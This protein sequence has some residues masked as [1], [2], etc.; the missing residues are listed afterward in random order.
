[1]PGAAM[2]RP[3]RQGAVYTFPLMRELWSTV[4]GPLYEAL[5]PAVVVV[6]ADDGDP[7]AAQVA[8]A[9][10]AAG[11]RLV[12]V[13]APE[14]APEDAD[15]VV[16]DMLRVRHG[17]RGRPGSVTVVFG[18]ENA[19]DRELEPTPKRALE[20]R[21]P[22]FGGLSIVVP[23]RLA[24]GSL[25]PFVAAMRMGSVIAAQL[26]ALERARMGVVP[27]PFAEEEADAR[28]VALTRQ[29][30]LQAKEIAELRVRAATVDPRPTG[31]PAQPEAEAK[32]DDV[33]RDAR[34]AERRAESRFAEL[35]QPLPLL[36][37][38]GW[39]GPA[40]DLALP[41]PVDIR[42]MLTT[43]ELAEAHVCVTV[44]DEHPTRATLRA[45]LADV[46]KPVSVELLV[47]AGAMDTVRQ[48][49][50]RLRTAEPLFQIVEAPTIRQPPAL[51]LEAGEEL[52]AAWPLELPALS[53]VG[54]VLPGIPAGGSG[55]SHSIVQEAL[56]LVGLGIDVVIAVPKAAREAVTDAY[57]EAADL[58]RP[59]ANP[60][61]LE[62]ALAGREVLVATEHPSVAPVIDAARH[63]GVA[64]AYYVQDYE[65]LFAEKGSPRADAAVLSYR[66]DASL[67][68]FAKTHWLANV[69]AARHQLSV[70]K[71]L[72]SLDRDLFHREGRRVLP[73]GGPVRVA[74]MV[75]PRTPR[76]RPV[77]MAE[78][79][80][81]LHD[82]LGSAVELVS[83]GCTA[84]ELGTLVARPDALDHRGILSRSA[85][86][87]L[88]RQ[89]DV[90]VDLSI[91]Q[92]FGRTGLEAMACGAVPVLP[93][94]GGAA[95]YASDGVNA[96]LVDGA[97]SSSVL[98][99]VAELVGDTERVSAM[100]EAGE[101]S[102]QR[103]GIDAAAARLAAC[104]AAFR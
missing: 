54:Y 82:R 83:F 65:P 11:A 34:R 1:M 95:E 91:Y 23:A 42:G 67:H 86:A 47:P 85:V 30:A 12:R 25:A 98:A 80:L 38:L 21:I 66:A 14:L 96:I 52:P 45:V 77:A 37:A 20:V 43:A 49:A 56:G 89:S 4:V 48:L 64:A 92:A 17:V 35:Y 81:A 58:I 75:R 7:L 31:P 24:N 100:S 3:G 87:D 15:L 46:Q 28:V 39:P 36:D 94:L 63:H 6:A 97:D 10:E 73:T 16:A 68:L 51:T 70:T 53:S 8:Y 32:P 71:V 5:Q 22:G 41:I 19:S 72:P 59:Y 93:A 79:L 40:E 104:F 44:G 33:A 13:D 29:L 55:G 2:S 101:T 9:A 69:V 57:P 102:V 61:E 78:L 50:D 62:N 84:E 99:A 103:F 88:L 90:F 18:L 60:A 76:R 27:A 26:V 74:A